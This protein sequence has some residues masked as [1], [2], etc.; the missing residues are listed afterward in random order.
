M[1]VLI[2]TIPFGEMNRLPLDLL[3]D[4]RVDYVINPHN[5]KLKEHQLAELIGEFDALIAGTEIIS[6]K[7]MECAPKLKL[8]SRVGIGLDGIDLNAAR[9]RNITVSYT[10]N[11]PTLAVAELT[12]GLM[13][14][15]IRS[16]HVSN[17]QMHRGQWQRIFG[18]RIENSVIGIIGAG[19]IGSCVLKLLSVF[20]I[21]KIMVNDIIQNHSLNQGLKIE[22]ASKDEIYKYADIISIH[23]PLTKLTYNLIRKEQLRSMKSDTVIINTSRGG[24]INEDDLYDVMNDGHLRGVALDVFK[25]EPYNGKLAKIDRCLLTAHMGSMSRDCRERM[26]I[27]ATEEVIRLSKGHKMKNIVPELEYELHNT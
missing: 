20:G 12:L 27:E 1:K 3:E 19:R 21:K 22:Y 6:N 2:T 7:V 10:P 14:S 8:I 11:A 5:K 4:S 18:T 26:E 16:T 17:M 13:I 25:D 23:L 24:I 15:L 9:K